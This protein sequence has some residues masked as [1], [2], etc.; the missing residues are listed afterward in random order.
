LVKQKLSYLD[1][2]DEHVIK[3][4]KKRLREIKQTLIEIRESLKSLG[5]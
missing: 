1:Q 4:M 5:G 2:S 3:E